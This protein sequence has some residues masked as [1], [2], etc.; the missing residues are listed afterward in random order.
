MERKDCALSVKNSGPCLVVENL[1]KN[2]GGLRAVDRV[3]LTI[4]PGE[5]RVLMGPNGAGKTTI[6]N[7]LSGVY[8]A[9]EGRI[10]FFD[11]DVT[12]LP[13]YRRAAL[14]IARTYQ[15][16]NLFQKLTVSENI[17]MAC[18]ALVRTKFVMFRPLSS[19]HPLGNRCNELLKE[20]D[21]WDKR[22]TLV[23][24]LSHGDQR[25][26][27]VALALAQ[28]P[29]LLLLDEPS[30]GL[31][32]AE[33]HA[34]TLLLKKLDPNITILLIEHDMDVAFEFAEKITVLYHG[35]F[36]TEGTKEEIKNN[37]TV[38]E[39]YLGAE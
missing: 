11:K 31:S 14:G 29:R 20:F 6:F 38:Q 7:L 18:Q 9:S 17:L 26:I 27:E 3:N 23:K 25:Q 39:I 10:L 1:T 33:T 35:K 16:T 12:G 24:N 28:E 13:P 4:E 2:F 32:S 21:L 8:P 37:P 34:L 36:L 22:N 5:R 15:I 30:A 19:Y